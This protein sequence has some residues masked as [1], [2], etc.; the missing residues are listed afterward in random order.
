MYVCTGNWATGVQVR[1]CEQ[2]RNDKTSVCGR[3]CGHSSQSH[4]V[5]VSPLVRLRAAYGVR[6]Y[7]HT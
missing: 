6:T 4:P 7:V 2:V 5:V 3:G 1:T